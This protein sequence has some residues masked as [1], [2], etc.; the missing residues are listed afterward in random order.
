MALACE[1]TGCAPPLVCKNSKCVVQCTQSSQCMEN[2]ECK[3]NQCVVKTAMITLPCIQQDGQCTALL[4]VDLFRGPLLVAASVNLSSVWTPGAQRLTMKLADFVDAWNN[5]WGNPGTNLGRL[6]ISPVT[7]RL[8][9]SRFRVPS[10]GTFVIRGPFAAWWTAM[11]FD[12]EWS[13]YDMSGVFEA[14]RL[15]SY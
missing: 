9:M 11:G 1:T 10:P 15:P 7:G 2:E 6:S 5:S 13:T 3:S 12:L 14:S 4:G 8:I